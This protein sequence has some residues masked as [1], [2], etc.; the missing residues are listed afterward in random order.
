[1]GDIDKYFN[2]IYLEM[3]QRLNLYYSDHCGNCLYPKNNLFNNMKYVSIKVN[4]TSAAR[5]FSEVSFKIIFF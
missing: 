5:K 2:F 3:I 1:M 4:N